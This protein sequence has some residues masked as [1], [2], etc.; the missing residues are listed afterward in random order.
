[1]KKTVSCWSLGSGEYL[2]SSPEGTKELLQ[3]KVIKRLVEAPQIS[4][5]K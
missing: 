3:V 2:I 5:K 1:M 4:A